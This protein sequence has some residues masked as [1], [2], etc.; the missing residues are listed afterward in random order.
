MSHRSPLDVTGAISKLFGKLQGWAEAVILMLPN[1]V[2]AALAVA[3]GLFA[4]RWLPRAAERMFH[5]ATSNPPVSRLLASVLRVGIIVLGAMWALSLL[6]L[7]KAVTSMLAGVGVLGLAL[8]FAF[9]D[10]AANFMSGFMMTLNRPFEVGDLVEVAGRQCRVL[11]VELRATELETLDGLTILIPNKQVFQN[12]IVNYTRTP[13]RRMDLRVGVAY[14]DDM[15]AVR[16]VVIEAVANVPHRDAARA[17]ELFFEQ[18]GDSSIDF[19]LRIWLSESKQLAYLEARS[20]AMIA[21]KNALDAHG[22]TIPFPIRTLDFGAKVVGG[23]PL[24]EVRQ[25]RLLNGP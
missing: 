7:D 21:V 19:Q 25:N 4:S 2:L 6:N 10:I 12:A 13:Q 14:C 17:V 1:L 18:F 20:E 23:T 5:R 9:Q 3:I 11:R 24:D 8:G 16:R 15:V 22:M